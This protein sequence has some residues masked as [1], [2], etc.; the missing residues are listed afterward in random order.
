MTTSLDH[1]TLS[2]LFA[3]IEEVPSKGRSPE[4]PGGDDYERKHPDDVIDIPEWQ[5]DGDGDP[6]GHHFDG[7]IFPDKEGSML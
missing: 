5:D 4:A 3:E 2:I 6:N 1:I 7:Y